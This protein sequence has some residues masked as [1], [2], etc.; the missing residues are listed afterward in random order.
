MPKAF[1]SAR[2]PIVIA[3]NQITGCAQP[4]SNLL[5]LSRLL[6]PYLHGGEN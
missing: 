6:H 3:N 4:A 1:Q 2:D 5:H